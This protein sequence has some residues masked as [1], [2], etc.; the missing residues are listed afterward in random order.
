[1]KKIMLS[2][3]MATLLISCGKNDKECAEWMEGDDCKTETRTKY[4]FLYLGGTVDDPNAQFQFMVK[5]GASLNE[6]NIN[7]FQC[8]LQSPISGIFIIK[9]NEY[10]GGTQYT[11]E[12]SFGQ[13]V[14]DSL[15]MHIT[16]KDEYFNKYEVFD[17]IAKKW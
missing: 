8:V 4:C 12:G 11:D 3:S 7:K 2:L 14:G 9:S 15:Y 17:F 16:T 5:R 13:F 1:M 10:I 6:V